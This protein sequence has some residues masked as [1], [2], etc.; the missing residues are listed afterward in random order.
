MSAAAATPVLTT[1]DPTW[2][3]LGLLHR[4]IEYG[5]ALAA[6]LRQQSA[7]ADL[8]AAM[9]PFGTRDIALILARITRGLQRAAALEERV[10]CDAARRHAPPPDQP[11]GTSAARRAA[12]PRPRTAPRAPSPL[13]Q[14]PTPERI[15]A[16]VRRRPI[17]SVIT[18]IC[19]DLGITPEHP[20]WREVQSAIVRHGGWPH[21]L[22]CE[23]MQRVLQSIALDEADGAA[24]AARPI[25]ASPPPS[26]SPGST[27]PP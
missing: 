6:T 9:R 11:A 2:R 23:G 5:K 27:G 19:L 22:L 17:A 1:T 13:A 25:A 16:E 18:D 3:L 7:T 8:A 26:P 24:P 21:R 14:L 15:A 4:L 10:I 12:A 20:L